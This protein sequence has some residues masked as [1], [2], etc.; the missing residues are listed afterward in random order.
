M[1]I[2]QK[3]LG[4]WID[5][6]LNWKEHVERLTIKLKRNSHT[7]YQSKK[8]LTPHAK[9]I[10]YFTQIYSHLIYGLSI[11]GNMTSVKH[12]KKIKQVQ[13]NC[14]KCIQSTDKFLT[15]DDLVKLENFKFGWKTVNKDLPVEL[16]RCA[17]I[18]QMG[19]SLNKNYKYETRNKILPK[20]PV[21]KTKLYSS[22]IFVTGANVLQ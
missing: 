11:W 17:T 20:M 13:H 15:L 14:I 21:A 19:L 10:I 16:L 9:K 2:T 4:V 12:L 1:S 8:F 7:L 18:D 6:K 5:N 3:F 22:S